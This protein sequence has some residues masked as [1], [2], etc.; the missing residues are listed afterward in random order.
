MN[1]HRLV[2]ICLLF[3]QSTMVYSQTDSKIITP[4]EMKQIEERVQK[5]L[6]S[7]NL[8]QKKKFYLNLLAGREL[9]QYRFYDKAK[10]Y[11]QNAIKMN[12]KED[13]TEAFINL[14]AIA[15]I[16]KDKPKVQLA[17]DQAKNYFIEYP[18]FKNQEIDYYLKSID[19]YLPF[20]NEI[21]PKEI[22][23]FYGRFAH[24]ENLINL[25]KNKEYQK[26]FSNLNPN[27][28]I[29]A[30]DDFNITVFDSLNVLL[31]KKSVNAL[32]CNKQFKKYPTSY[33]YNII[34]CGLLNDYL[35]NGKFD[36]KHL[37]RAEKYF[38]NEDIEKYY[39]L[40]MIKEIN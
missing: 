26:A 8:D 16:K 9:Y 11:Y 20:K 27:A 39:L 2:L 31:N 12:I 40:T 36:S 10:I 3:T 18:K 24:E 6:A 22:T 13:K 37:K 19:K 28:M 38:K 15:I 35:H 30:E 1:L 32:F 4:T 21:D 17:Y 33:A 5:E 25:L 23:G 29:N 14:I 34:I 7:K